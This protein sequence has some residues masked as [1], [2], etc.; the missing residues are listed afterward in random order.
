LGIIFWDFNM[1]IVKDKASLKRRKLN[2]Q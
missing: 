1:M 2:Q